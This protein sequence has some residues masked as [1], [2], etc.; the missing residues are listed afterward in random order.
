[1]N[2]FFQRLFPEFFPSGEG[3]DHL[4]LV[5]V[6]LAAGGRV[7]IPAAAMKRVSVATKTSVTI[8]HGIDG[9]TL[10]VKVSP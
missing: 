5:A 4:R 2:D 7:H 8:V 1:M 9:I 10:E 3:L 6:V